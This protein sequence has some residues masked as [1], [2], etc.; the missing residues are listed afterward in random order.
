MERDS[1]SPEATD[2]AQGN[3]RRQVGVPRGAFEEQTNARVEET[4][5]G[6]TERHAVLAGLETFQQSEAVLLDRSAQ[7]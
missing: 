3:A 2:R 5:V 4:R 6:P 1:A 7:R